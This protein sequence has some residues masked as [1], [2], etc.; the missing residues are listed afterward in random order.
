MKI[1]DYGWSY[2]YKGKTHKFE[3]FEDLP[4]LPIGS[5]YIIISYCSKDRIRNMYGYLYVLDENGNYIKEKRYQGKNF[6]FPLQK[7]I[8]KLEKE[9]LVS[10]NF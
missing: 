10:F 3:K 1:L 4:A 2:R 8:A 9:G 5:P 7:A 6:Y